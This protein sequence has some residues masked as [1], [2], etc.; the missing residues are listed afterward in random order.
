[1]AIPVR[2]ERCRFFCWLVWNC[3][4][5]PNLTVRMCIAGPHYRPTV[6]E[7]RDIADVRFLR[8][9]YIFG[10]PGIDNRPDLAGAHSRKSP[11]VARREAQNAANPALG[12][13]DQ[14]S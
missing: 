8:E 1:M 2:N 14:Q 5:G 12:S 9:R 11:I 6:F 13:S 7:D 4:G 10:D 3:R